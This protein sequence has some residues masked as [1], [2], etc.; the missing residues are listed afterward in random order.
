MKR[1]LVLCAVFSSALSCVPAVSQ[2]AADLKGR[3]TDPSGT[4]VANAAVELSNPATSA[5]QRSTSSASGDYG[6]TNL[7]PGQYEVDVTAEGFDHLT[8]T[9]ITAIVGQTVTVD[10]TLRVG[11]SHQTVT[12]T[13]PMPL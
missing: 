6:F 13:T 3:V 5:H 12:V 4:G 8:R 10:L 7:N 9:G 1:R 11:G 2:I